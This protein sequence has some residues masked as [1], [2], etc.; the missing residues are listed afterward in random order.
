MDNLGYPKIILPSW[1]DQ[2]D[3]NGT[4]Y[5][6]NAEILNPRKSRR[7]LFNHKNPPLHHLV[8]PVPIYLT[9]WG[10]SSPRIS[11][12]PVGAQSVAPKKGTPNVLRKA[13]SCFFWKPSCQVSKVSKARKIGGLNMMGSPKSGANTSFSGGHSL[14]TSSGEPWTACCKTYSSAKM[15]FD[16]GEPREVRAAWGK[17]CSSRYES[18]WTSENDDCNNYENR[19]HNKSQQSDKLSCALITTITIF[20][21]QSPWITMKYDVCNWTNPE[22]GLFMINDGVVNQYN[23]CD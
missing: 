10:Q 17:S 7:I 3:P 13:W 2:T 19:R 22:N 5:Q 11:A 15:G 9:P 18:Q 23:Q 20:H 12:P 6:T 14:P 16:L 21:F 1:L 8:S 4:K